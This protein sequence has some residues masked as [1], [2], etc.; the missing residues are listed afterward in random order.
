MK[1][2]MLIVIEQAGVVG[3][4]PATVRVESARLC[5]CSAI[6]MIPLCSPCSTSLGADADELQD[7]SR[8]LAGHRTMLLV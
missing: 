3:A 4:G 7:R 2:D 1:L 6:T 8:S 5:S